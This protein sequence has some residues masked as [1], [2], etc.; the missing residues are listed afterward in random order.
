MIFDKA[1]C[2]RRKGSPLRSDERA[3]ERAPLTADTS[4]QIIPIVRGEGKRKKKSARTKTTRNGVYTKS[5]TLPRHLLAF[6]LR[7][8]WHGLEHLLNWSDWRH[9]Q[10]A[11]LD[12]C[13]A[14]TSAPERRRL[15]RLTFGLPTTPPETRND[16]S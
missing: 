4:G 11:F 7:G 13:R 12:W 6:V 8:G 3:E 2:A 1:G 16:G 5:R 9:V 10:S 15:A 14:D